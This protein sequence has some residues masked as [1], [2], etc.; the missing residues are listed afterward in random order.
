M[1]PIIT[2]IRNSCDKTP[3]SK[4]L[5]IQVIGNCFLT[6]LYTWGIGYSER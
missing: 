1:D 3:N 6:L 4:G 2:V 5:Y